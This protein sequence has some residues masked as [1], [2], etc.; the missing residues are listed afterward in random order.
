[1]PYVYTD[2]TVDGE[3]TYIPGQIQMLRENT[4]AE[5]RASAL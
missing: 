3:V 2:S 5:D 4:F 1:M